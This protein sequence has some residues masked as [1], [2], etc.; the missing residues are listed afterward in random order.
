M[1]FIY[2]AVI[3]VSPAVC[4]DIQDDTINLGYFSDQWE[5]G[6]VADEFFAEHIKPLVDS[7]VLAYRG[8]CAVVLTYP[9][10]KPIL[11]PREH[12]LL[13]DIINAANDE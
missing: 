11:D 8:S 9:I 5:A 7:G 4:L 10:D 3:F 1:E 6:R 13:Q 12:P 2:K